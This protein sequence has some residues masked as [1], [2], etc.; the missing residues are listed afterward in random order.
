MEVLRY[1]SYNYLVLFN[2]QRRFNILFSKV[3]Q[4]QATSTTLRD[5]TFCHAM[6][7]SGRGLGRRR[8]AIRFPRAI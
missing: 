8:R 4:G 2:L 3:L 7:G 1:G 6:T 5:S